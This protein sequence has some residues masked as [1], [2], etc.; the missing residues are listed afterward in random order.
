MGLGILNKKFNFQYKI[1]Y[2]LSEEGLGILSWEFNF[3]YKISFD[4]LE[5]SKF[6]I[7]NI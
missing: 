4:L 5:I 6:S 1:S 2:D 3:Q 7:I